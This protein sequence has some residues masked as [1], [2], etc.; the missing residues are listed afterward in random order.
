MTARLTDTAREGITRH[1]GPQDWTAVTSGWAAAKASTYRTQVAS[2]LEQHNRIT[3]WCE[4]HP[5][6][7]DDLKRE[8]AGQLYSLR[9]RQRR[10]RELMWAWQVLAGGR[11]TAKS[12]AALH[13][14]YD[15]NAA[16]I[17]ELRRRD[18]H[19]RFVG[20]T[21][22]DTRLR[23]SVQAPRRVNGVAGRPARVR[24]IAARETTSN[25][26]GD[27]EP[28]PAGRLSHARTAVVA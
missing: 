12:P 11:V 20:M 28:E 22:G 7:P 23:L 16:T 17:R 4:Q 15:R 9:C 26:P 19:S 21:L 18:D 24:R 25:D 14:E 3:E 1:E 27:S 2:C 6:I 13:A 5:D 8:I 10:A